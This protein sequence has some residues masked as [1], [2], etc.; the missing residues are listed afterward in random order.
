MAQVI[1]VRFQNPANGEVLHD[2]MTLASSHKEAIEL[3][4][5]NWS[6]RTGKIKEMCKWE[7]V[8][9]GKFQGPPKSAGPCCWRYVY[10]VALEEEEYDRSAMAVLFAQ[11]REKGQEDEQ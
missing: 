6:G 7:G 2:D 1:E 3:A 4:L 5:D 10:Y 9:Q 8:E 11:Y